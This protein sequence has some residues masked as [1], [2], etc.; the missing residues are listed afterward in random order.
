VGEGDNAGVCFAS[1]SPKNYSI[2]HFP[3]KYKPPILFLT[4]IF[5]VRLVYVYSCGSPA[6]AVDAIYELG[7]EWC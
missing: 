2:K 6:S 7:Y 5:F 3:L 4:I 1:I